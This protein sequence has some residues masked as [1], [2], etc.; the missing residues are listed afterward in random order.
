MQTEPSKPDPPKRRRRRFQSP[1]RTLMIGVT[2]LAVACG[3]V[4]WRAKIVTARKASLKLHRLATS[5]SRQYSQHLL[6]EGDPD[7]PPSLLRRWLGDEQQSEL[8]V[9]PFISPSEL[10]EIITLFPE[11]TITAEWRF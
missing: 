5:G 10:K 8:E 2:L 9:S 3:Y 11:A 1:L 7:K 6:V 4:G